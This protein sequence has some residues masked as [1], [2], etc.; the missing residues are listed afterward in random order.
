[1]ALTHVHTPITL[2]GLTIPNRV[3]RSAHA[4]GLGGGT[5]LMSDD[6]IAY[7][8]ARAK[9]GVGLTM[10]EILSVHWS[11]P[12]TLNAWLPD[13]GDGYRRLVDAVKPHG[14]RLFQQLWHA[15]H[16]ALPQDGSPPW[17]ASDIP[18]LQFGVAPIPMTK[19]MIDEVIASYAK[20]ARDC[21]AWGLDG[22]ELHGCHGYLP[23]Q[24][25]SLNANKRED[26][27]GG[28][29]DNRAR[30]TI[31]VMTA[32]RAAVS[33]GFVVGIRVGDD[34]TVGGVDAQDYLRLT[35]MLEDR[36]LVD[37]I[38]ISFGNKQAYPRMIGGMHEPAGYE[39]P[40][41]T[42][43]SRRI[44]TPS[45]VIGRFRTLE[46]A[47]QVIRSGDAQMVAMTRATIADPDM[48]RKSLA[49]AEDQVRPC[50]GCNQ[51]CVGGLKSTGRMGCVVNP[52]V[53]HERRIGDDRLQHAATPRKILV[54]GGGPAGME[55]ARVAATRGHHVI[56]CEADRRLGG[57]LRLAAR[58]PGRTG[59]TD[60]T[61]WLEQELYRL[62]VEV[63]LNTYV[64]ADDV[65]AE[66]A[67]HVI[68]ATGS[69]PRLD[70]IQLANPGEPATG[71]DDPKVISS[72]DLMLDT[73]PVSARAAVVVDDT[74]HY[75]ALAVAE[76]LIANGVAVT[77]ITRQIAVGYLMEPALM[78]D[79]ALQRLSLGSIT[80][81]TRSR[82]IA[83]TPEGVV[84][85][86][87][88]V[89]TGS[90]HAVNIAADMVVVI[91]ANR[92]NRDLY[93]DLVDRG[94]SADVIGDANAPRYLGAAICE[95]NTIGARV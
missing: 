87:T 75:E 10:L 76:H 90:N 78:V 37:F 25:L 70:G 94:I 7:H 47:D 49:G 61:V 28:S 69:T 16:N 11:S 40:T 52:A 53:G 13:L 22:V 32:I 66:G 43:I 33:P 92:P 91:S 1:M 84:A 72:N 6:L 63:R 15:G 65:A 83:V 23:A 34:N 48:V 24:F 14:M 27:Y 39:L 95:G 89:A 30:F 35:T 31:E 20:A 17:S 82:L 12:G 26:D 64:D 21:E 73:G 55:A 58:P 50:I 51:G 68:V 56:L 80:C 29:F 38:D 42:Q 59:I 67:D 79:P 60:I 3:V 45:I 4:T 8:L 54:V 9:G 41:S 36:G 44:R 19:P 46:E 2:N 85:G 88:Y 71:M 74:G 57:T 93:N 81:M 18:G 86:P 77:F 62:G 5:G